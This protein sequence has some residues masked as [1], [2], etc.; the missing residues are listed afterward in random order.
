MG[1]YYGA[2]LQLK[3]RRC[4]V[5]GGG[6]VAERKAAGLLA[7]EAQVTLIAPDVTNVIA[8]WANLG[9]ITWKARPFLAEDV[10][11]MFLV[12]AATDSPDVNRLAAAAAEEEGKLV[13][14]VDDPDSGN[15]TVPAMVRRGRLQIGVSTSGASPLVAKRIKQELDAAFGEEYALYLDLLDEVRRH[16]LLH[17]AEERRRRELFQ[18]VARPELLALLKAGKE[19]EARRRIADIIGGLED[20]AN[21][22]GDT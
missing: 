18:A 21:C 3:G 11:E 16:V 8:N 17:V 20:E 12:I 19:A 10:R 9:T 13:N 6:P 22:C 7:C 5:V 14:V 2:F 4:L 15:F 1:A